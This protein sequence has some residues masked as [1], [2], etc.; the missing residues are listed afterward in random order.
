MTGNGNVVHL[1]LAR[2]D[3]GRRVSLCETLDRVLNKG[4]VVAGEVTISLAGVELV[5]LGLQLRLMSVE[6]ARKG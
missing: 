4:I 6:T 5:Y 2:F 1:D 3:D